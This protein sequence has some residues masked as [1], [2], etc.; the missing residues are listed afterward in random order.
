MSFS[1]TQKEIAIVRTRGVES[2]SFIPKSKASPS[3][4]V[5][6]IGTLRRKDSA[7]PW[8]FFPPYGVFFFG[9]SADHMQ[10]ITNTMKP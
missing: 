7:S 5:D 9:V 8:E 2:L 1:A 3:M 6:V 4:G 10:Q